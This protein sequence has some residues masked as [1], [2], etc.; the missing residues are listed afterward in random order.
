MTL[1][2]STH[3]HSTESVS[4]K[5][6]NFGK[7]SRPRV[8][9]SKEET[10]ANYRDQ[11][12][13][14]TMKNSRLQ[15]MLQNQKKKSQIL[16]KDSVKTAFSKKEDGTFRS[17]LMGTLEDLDRVTATEDETPNMAELR[18]NVN[19][20]IIEVMKFMEIIKNKD[21]SKYLEHDTLEYLQNAVAN[22]DKLESKSE[23]EEK[24]SYNYSVDFEQP[25]EPERKN[26]SVSA[27][28]ISIEKTKSHASLAEDSGTELHSISDEE[29][30]KRVKNISEHSGFPLLTSNTSVQ[31]DSPQL[32]EIINKEEEQV[33]GDEKE[34]EEVDSDESKSELGLSTNSLLSGLDLSFKY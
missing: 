29:S 10:F 3:T 9:D 16:R 34:V 25:M 20:S 17:S 6:W 11:I 21:L 7:Y 23:H 5:P 19:K 1:P 12:R 28:T 26:S 33:E 22:Q 24:V 2:F 8:E 14:L 4:Q 32:T 13:K 15:V 31:R 27:T 18:E 30:A